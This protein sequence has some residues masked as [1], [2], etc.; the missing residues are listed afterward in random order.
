MNAKTFECG[1]LTLRI[2]N[3]E[4]DGEI[5]L[6]GYNGVLW[7]KSKHEELT[8]FVPLYA[9]LNLEHIFDGS[10]DNPEI[11]FEP[12]RAAM[13][14]KEISE[15]S[16]QLYQPPTPHYA[17]ESWTDFTLV[18]PYYV[19]VRFRCKPH[20]ADAFKMGYLGLFW[21]S[22]ITAPENTAIYFRGNVPGHESVSVWNALATQY[23]GHA[24]SVIHENDKPELP[25]MK[26]ERTDWLFLNFSPLRYSLPFYFGRFRDMALIYMFDRTSGIRITHSPSGG[27]THRFKD[28]RNPAWDFQYIVPNPN[29]GDIYSLRYRFAYKKYIDREDV[30]AEYTAWHKSLGSAGE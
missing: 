25:F 4:P 22:Y 13:E 7:I 18:E 16:C 26:T 3:N 19:D 14:F 8:P 10:I 23:H 11:L 6:K 27:G 5:H 28:F 20:R 30:L 29:A 1:E 21:A 2:G 9:G 12:R 15:R 17:L 24:S